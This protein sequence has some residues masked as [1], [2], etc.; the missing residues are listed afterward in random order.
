MCRFTY[1]LGDEITVADLVTRPENSLI[2]Q[3]THARERPEPLNPGPRW[4]PIERNHV[5]LVSSDRS[6]SFR[7]LSAC[8]A[9]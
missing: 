8:S 1:Y 7:E 4:T 5:A 6:V 3:S 9:D 2:H